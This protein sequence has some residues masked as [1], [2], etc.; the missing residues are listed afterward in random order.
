VVD[1][2]ERAPNERDKVFSVERERENV[3]RIS[4]GGDH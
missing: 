3:L 4:L 1:V 2:D